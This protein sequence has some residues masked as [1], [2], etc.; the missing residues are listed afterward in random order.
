MSAE[1]IDNILLDYE[2]QI[3]RNTSNDGVFSFEN[4]Y[5]SHNYFRNTDG[6]FLI[7][8]R[9]VAE[10]KHTRISILDGDWSILERIKNDPLFPE[11]HEE[12]IDL[13]NVLVERHDDVG[14]SCCDNFNEDTHTYDGGDKRIVAY[15]KWEAKGEWRNEGAG[16]YYYPIVQWDMDAASQKKNNFGFWVRHR[17]HW[18]FLIS[19][20][21]RIWPGEPGYVEEQ[22]PLIVVDNKWTSHVSGTGDPI[23]FNKRGPYPVPSGAGECVFS[24]DYDFNLHTNLSLQPEQSLTISCTPVVDPCDECPSGWNLNSGACYS[25]ICAPGAFVWGNNMWYPAVNGQCSNG[26]T[27]K[28]GPN[29]CYLGYFPG[30]YGDPFVWNDCFWIGAGCPW[31]Q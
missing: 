31:D 25:G 2:G 10:H 17:R 13:D 5:F 27:Y 22:T 6:L 26:G 9:I 24:V 16:W 12:Y 29:A 4:K 15:Y 18:T 1:E 19:A 11:N 28:S 30:V 3:I 8:N 21:Y 14:R 23:M 20:I 7:G